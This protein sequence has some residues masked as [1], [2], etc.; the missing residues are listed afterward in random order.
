MPR[1]GPVV[2][3]ESPK[4]DKQERAWTTR[5]PDGTARLERYKQASTGKGTSAGD[6]CHMGG[7]QQCGLD[8]VCAMELPERPRLKM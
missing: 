1:A 7:L 6:G 2:E 5:S 3:T 8:Q 4:G